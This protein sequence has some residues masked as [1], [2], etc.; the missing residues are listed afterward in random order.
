MDIH[1]VTWDY[2]AK[3]SQK[4]LRFYVYKSCYIKLI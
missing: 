1:L 3:L 2:F 4:D